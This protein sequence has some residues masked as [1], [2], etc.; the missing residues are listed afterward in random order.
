MTPP[1]GVLRIARDEL[2]RWC[3]TGDLRRWPSLVA[4]YQPREL[5]TLEAW[6]GGDERVPI[7]MVTDRL[8]VDHERA[9]V[10]VAR[11]TPPDA[12]PNAIASLLCHR[13]VLGRAVILVGDARF[14]SKR[15]SNLALAQGH[16][17]ED[18]LNCKVCGKK[19]SEQQKDRSRCCD[20]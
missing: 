9:Q 6:I 13:P 8:F 5:E 12:E 16:Q 14:K 10:Y 20:E 17:F 4:L 18:D 15:Q 1:R 2:E 19:W 3:R 7:E 11:D